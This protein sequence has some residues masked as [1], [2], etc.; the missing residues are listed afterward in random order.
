LFYNKTNCK[1]AKGEGCFGKAIGG[2]RELIAKPGIE[3]RVGVALEVY[4]R[5]N[6]GTHNS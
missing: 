4:G 1:V 6:T 3:A 2:H 5:K